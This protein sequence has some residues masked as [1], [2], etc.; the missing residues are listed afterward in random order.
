MQNVCVCGVLT[1][2]AV[3]GFPKYRL[4]GIEWGVSQVGIEWCRLASCFSSA[5]NIV[6]VYISKTGK[7]IYFIQS[8]VLNI[9]ISYKSSVH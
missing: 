3:K 7:K 8:S 4:M 1:F 6:G 9:C 5:V 2:L